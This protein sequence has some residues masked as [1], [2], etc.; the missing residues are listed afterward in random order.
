[1]DKSGYA[2]A[3][4]DT[5]AVSL[6]VNNTYETYKATQHIIDRTTWWDDSDSTWNDIDKAAQQYR[7]IVESID[8]HA[9]GMTD[10]VGIDYD[11]VDFAQLIRDELVERNLQDGR[12]GLAGLE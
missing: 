2:I 3:H 5:A 7:E 10:L 1:M 12:D 6:V 11:A 9:D 4:G 8:R